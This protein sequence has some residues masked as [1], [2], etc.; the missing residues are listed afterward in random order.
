MSDYGVLC[1]DA[2]KAVPNNDYPVV[3]FSHE[4]EYEEVEPHVSSFAELFI[5]FESHLDDWITTYRRRQNEQL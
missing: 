2:N 1:F 5:E 3:E 4:D